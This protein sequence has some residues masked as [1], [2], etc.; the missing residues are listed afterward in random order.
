MAKTVIQ[1]YKDIYNEL[2]IVAEKYS[3]AKV[4]YDFIEMMALEIA[5][6]IGHTNKEERL[7]KTKSQYQKQYLIHYDNF[8]M[9]VIEEFQ[10]NRFQDVFGVLFHELQLHNNF[11]GQFFT[12]FAVSQSIAKMSITESDLQKQDFLLMNEPACG[13]GGIIIA[14]SQVVE[15]LNYNYAE[16]LIWV[17]QDIDL[18]CVHMCFIQLNLTGVAAI[19]QHSNS[20][21]VEVFESFY[22][23]AHLLN[24]CK[25]RL[26]N[27]F[28]ENKTLKIIRDMQK[29]EKDETEKEEIQ[30]K[31][32][33]EKQFDFNF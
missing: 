16:K 31:E 33:K 23:A 1:K 21:S 27:R 18:H 29:E 6:K 28:R 25:T 14:A 15:E 8:K 4:F 3:I 9:L 30:N 12:P 13:S 26:E 19:I 24:N 5:I 10:K 17:A 20:L 7:N 22:T 2:M 11:K 32:N